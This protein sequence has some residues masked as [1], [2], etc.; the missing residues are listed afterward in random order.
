M[1]FRQRSIKLYIA[2]NLLIIFAVITSI[3]VNWYTSL[4]AQKETLTANYLENNYNYAKKLSLSTSDLLNHMQEN[5]NALGMITG[6]HGMDQRELDIWLSANKEYFNSIF[7]TDHSGVIQTIS[8]KK[9]QYNDGVIVQ[10]GVQAKSDTFKKALK[11]KKPFISEPYRATSGQLIVLISSPIYTSEGNFSGVIGG[12]IYLESKN[13]LKETLNNHEYYNGSYVYVVDT[14]GQIIFHPKISRLNEN[15]IENKVVQSLVA[16]KAG[17][18]EVTNSKGDHYLAGYAPV[19]QTGWGI[20]SQTPKE[21][22]ETPLMK[23]QRKMAFQSL[24]LLLLI[25]VL[26]G[27]LARKISQPLNELAHYSE[28]AST[29]HHCIPLNKQLHLQSSIYEI[30]EL[31]HQ[32]DNYFQLLDSRIKIDGLTGLRNRKNFDEV[33]SRWLM[34]KSPFS[35]IMFDIDH[36]KQVNDTFGHVMGDD[37]LKH[38]SFLV[39]DIVRD[40]DNCFRYGGEEF[41]ILMKNSTIDQSFELAEAVRKKIELTPNPTGSKITVSLGVTTYNGEDIHAEK[42][43]KQADD[44]LYDSKKTGRNR[45]TKYSG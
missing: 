1:K 32:V 19:E 14:N 44:A 2:I 15:V 39:K 45:T 21:V 17:A 28:V 43:I 31:Y 38:F 29:K 24:P 23:L 20:V 7:I 18:T 42:L 4:K 6:Y 26:A 33:L 13:V 16:G 41:V 25:L 10:A 3:S 36:F 35:M 37:V 34:E 30:R 27:I 11:M 5:I 9:V 12:T 8:P 40:E 22:I